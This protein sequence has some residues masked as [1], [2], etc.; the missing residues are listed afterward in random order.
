[1]CQEFPHTHANMW[2]CPI[3]FS[4]LENYRLVNIEAKRSSCVLVCHAALEIHLNLFDVGWT[5]NFCGTEFMWPLGEMWPQCLQ[6][7][8]TPA[9]SYLEFS[10]SLTSSFWP[11]YPSPPLCNLKLFFQG[12]VKRFK[13][14]TL[15]LF[16]FLQKLPNLLNFSIFSIFIK[17]ILCVEHWTQIS[18]ENMPSVL[19]GNIVQ[20]PVTATPKHYDRSSSEISSQ[21]SHFELS[22]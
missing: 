15:I 7:Q 20:K 3:I 12:L 14:V 11:I 9:T 17:N 8:A 4:E 19:K 18:P 22:N 13:F 16:L 6:S 2:I 5:G 21:L 10:L 1:M